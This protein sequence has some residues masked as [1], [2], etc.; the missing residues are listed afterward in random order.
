M[1][2]R[3]VV[4]QNLELTILMRNDKTAGGHPPAMPLRAGPR[5]VSPYPAGTCVTAP[6]ALRRFRP[7]SSG[8]SNLP[9][10]V[11]GRLSDLLDRTRQRTG[12]AASPH[13]HCEL[14]K[15]RDTH[16]SAKL[17]RRS[18]LRHA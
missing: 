13:P 12:L 1:P 4:D 9:P 18:G 8:S 14:P 5:A 11:A 3:S 6:S 16:I 17:K 7:S 2:S 15:W 10:R